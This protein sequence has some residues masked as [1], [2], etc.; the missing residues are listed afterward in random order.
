MIAGRA[1][2]A[3]DITTEAY[4]Y[5]AG[6]DGPGVSAIFAEGWQGRQGGIS[7]GDL[8]WAATGERLTAGEVRALSQA[9]RLGRDPLDSG[10]DRA[11][12]AWRIR[13]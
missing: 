4:P 1:R 7:F 6:H 8:Q 10:G 9:G 3:L 2:A 11:A 12:G 13:W 5:T